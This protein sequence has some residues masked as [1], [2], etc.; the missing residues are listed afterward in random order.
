[1]D[2]D[3]GSDESGRYPGGSGGN[4]KKKIMN[5]LYLLICSLLSTKLLPK[6][7]IIPKS[8][9]GATNM[10][11][12]LGGL[13]LIISQLALKKDCILFGGEYCNFP[14]KTLCP[15]LPLAR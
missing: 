5:I 1:M 15:Y 13:G 3:T 9:D 4:K 8:R 12:K 11:S 2:P 7:N 10:I 6:D 14:K